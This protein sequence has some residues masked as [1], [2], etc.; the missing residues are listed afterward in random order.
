MDLN[1]IQSANYSFNITRQDVN[2]FGELAA[3]DRIITDTP[4]VSMDMSYI[5]ANFT[6]EHRLGFTVAQSGAAASSLTSCIGQALLTLQ[7]TPTKKIILF[8]L[9]EGGV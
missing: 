1:R 2:Q 6:N 5:L 7:Q 4:T 8:L 9:H 3:I